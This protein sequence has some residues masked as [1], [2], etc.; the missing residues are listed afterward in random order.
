MNLET[1]FNG[2]VL[3][4]PL[5][6]ASGPLSG[7]LEKLEYLYNQG[8]GAIVTKTISSQPAVVPRPCIYGG[9]DFVMNS[10]LWSELSYQTWIIDIL[11]NL[12]SDVPK[13]IS[14]GY[15]KEDMALL[16]PLLDPY[17][18]AFEI[19]T[20]YVGKDL[21]VIAET[22]KMIRSC[23]NKPV[24]MKISPHIPDPVG[25]AK[26]VRDAGASGIAA[27]NSLGPTMNIDIA[28][29]KIVYGNA[30]GYAWTSGPMIKNL[31]VAIVYMIKEAMPDFTV[32]GV[33]GIK[34]ADDVIEF[35]LAGASGV[36]MLSS[37]L[38]K[39]KDLYGKIIADLPKALEKYGFD[40]IEDVK[41]TA[42]D[43]RIS[44]EP[45]VPVVNHDTCTTC[46][47][48]EKICPYFAITYTDKIIMNPEK[49]FGCELCISKCPVKAISQGV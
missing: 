31:A 28:S 36:Q 38:L 12:P 20:H 6:P 21:F 14:V 32:I 35:L 9:K 19:S 44:F 26:A 22:V 24:F 13:I 5:M 37:A 18:D 48:C 39:G 3:K 42:L 4:N 17:A 46:M 47:L 2:L 10:E 8:I 15:T 11:P 45:K 49:C 25:F 41:A 30:D 34:T 29:R 7:D 16:I 33:G 1:R 43:R 23:T 27:I 40:S